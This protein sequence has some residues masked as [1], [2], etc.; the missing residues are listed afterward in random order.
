M[1]PFEFDEAAVRQVAEKLG[2]VAEHVWEVLLWQAT[3]GGFVAATTAIISATAA[4]VL[5]AY[6][7]HVFLV[8]GEAKEYD[9]PHSI[10]SVFAVIAACVFLVIACLCAN[11]AVF[12]LAN[13]EFHAMRLAKGLL[14]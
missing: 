8:T 1:K 11:E 7:R 12:K 10:L 4:V 6:L 14:P 2:V 5:A 9:S 3:V 13:P